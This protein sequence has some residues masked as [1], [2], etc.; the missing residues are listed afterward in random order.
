VLHETFGGN[1]NKDHAIKVF[2]RHNET[3]KSA[4]DTKRL[5]VFDFKE[6]WEPLCHFLGVQVPDEAFPRLN[7][8]VTIR[9]MVRQVRESERT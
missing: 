2:N 5:L 1:V 3:V 9:A 4:F 8:T 6:G 7:D